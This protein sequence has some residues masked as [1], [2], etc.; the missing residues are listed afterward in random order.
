MT[1]T[2][3]VR[4]GGDTGAASLEYAGIL[5]VVGLVVGALILTATPIGGALKSR[6]CEALDASCGNVAAQE[7]FDKLAKCVVR[8][9]DRTL[10][11]GGNVRFVNVD[12][13]DGDRFAVNSD[14]SASITLSQSTAAG[15][16]ITGKTVKKGG[17]DTPF[18]VDAKIQAAGDVA[19]VYNVP[20][21]WGGEDTAQQILDDKAGG[22]DRY[23]NLILGPWATSAAEGVNRL[24]DGVG[25]GVRWVLDK[26]GIDDESAEERAARERAESLS[27]ADAIQVSLGLQGSAS[28]SGDAG[29]VKG[30]ASGTAAAK[31]TV[32]VS[33][34]GSGEDKA[35]NSFTATV[36]LK[37]TLEGVVGWPGDGR[38]GQAPTGDIPPFLS[39]ALVGGALWSYR[40][41]YDNDGNPTKLTLTTEQSGQFQGGLKPPKVGLP[42]GN[43]VSINGKAN[44]AV[45]SMSVEE[46][47]LDL[48]DPANRAAFDDLFL[49]YGVGVADHHAQVSQMR[50]YEFSTLM[51]RA[52]ALQERVMQDALVMRY[53]YDL[54][55]TNVGAGGQQ[56]QSGADF[57]VA[58]VNWES[59]SLSRELTS[60]T[61]YDMSQGGLEFQIVDCG[62]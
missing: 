42:G 50:I 58:G 52:Q 8:R 4:A 5:T 61:A 35:S 46:V 45:G 40:V 41:D 60:A 34:N 62:S 2:R 30:S 31:G 11:F 55:G 54:Y 27:Q 14:G 59:S 36:D 56:R 38:P 12:R 33:L 24:A 20:E 25:T 37:G 22:I 17:K 1:G 57:V 43:G 6:V 29:L 28:V 32:Q 18:S 19:Y 13:K 26:T 7:R 16:G 21:S 9:D 49:T 51:D 15:V 47:V 44:G 39:G 23:G 10:A 48:T 3:R 53:E